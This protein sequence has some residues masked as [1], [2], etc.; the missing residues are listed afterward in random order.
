MR[1]RDI[2][3]PNLL[4]SEILEVLESQGGEYEFL[5][6]ELQLQEANA[7]FSQIRVT[8]RVSYEPT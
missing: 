8:S 5:I 1:V 4:V 3:D 2:S 7:F 6:H